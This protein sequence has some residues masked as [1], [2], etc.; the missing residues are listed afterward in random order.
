MKLPPDGTLAFAYGSNMHL[1]QMQSRCPKATSAGTGVLR[2]HRFRINDRGYA[3]IVPQRGGIVRGVLWILTPSDEAALDRYEGVAIGLY[4]KTT[5]RVTA[6]RSTLSAMVYVASDST[7]GVPKPGYL[8]KILEA[9]RAA[10]FPA[11]Y[12]DEIAGWAG[13][14]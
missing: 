7:P 13:D 5:L 9:A 4:T 10:G 1:G 11:A 8:E 2:G 3:T 6:G 12:I 14:G